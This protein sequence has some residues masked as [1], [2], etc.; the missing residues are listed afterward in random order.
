MVLWL[1]TGQIN[2]KYWLQIISRPVHQQALA[3]AYTWTK[4]PRNVCSRPHMDQTNLKDSFLTTHAINHPEALVLDYT[5]TNPRR[6]VS[7]WLHVYLT[8]QKY[9]ILPTHGPNHPKTLA[10]DYMSSK[11]STS[12][13]LDYT[14]A[15]PPTNISF[16]L[17]I[18]QT[19]KKGSFLT[20]HGPNQKHC[21]FH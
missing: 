13:G 19:T 14:R 4:P 15:K 18:D 7:S 5:W 10:S 16:W 17:H 20:T 2:Q 12:T 11:K 9:W 3:S 1:H 8:T 21:F 6:N